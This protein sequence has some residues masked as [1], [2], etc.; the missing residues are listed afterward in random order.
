M[1]EYRQ[2]LE[3][4]YGLEKLG[5]VFG[6]DNITRLLGLIG[7]PQ[8]S[9]KAVH[10]AGTNGKG[11]VASMLSEVL[12]AAG[13]A[14]G[15]YTSPHLVS[16]TERIDANGD[17]IT[18]AEVAELTQYIKERVDR[19]DCGTPFTFFDFTTAIAFEYFKRK[20]VAIALVEVGLGGRLDSTNVLRPLVSVITNVAFDHQEYLGNSLKEIAREK[21]GIVK[22][23]VPVVT[24]AKG[25]PLE[26]VRAAAAKT[27]L[28]ALD[29]N[30]TYKKKGEQLMWYRGIRT[31]Y[32][33]LS[34]G[35]RGD[36]Q[37]FNAALALCTLELLDR[38]GFP[39]KEYAV[40]KGLA[41]IKW[42]ARLELV[43]K[44]GKPLI[45]IDGAH[46]PDGA[47]ALAAYLKGHFVNRKKLLI[48]GV[49]KDK[50]FREM[51]REL[52][53]VVQQTILTR[54]EIGR[55]ALPA[56]VARY[57]PGALVSPSVGDALERA[58]AMAEEHD[59]IIITGSFYTAGEAKGLLDERP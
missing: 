8:E 1:K 9:L 40:R 28:Y 30:F 27:A 16:F 23:N 2:T 17:R 22:E 38:A 54:P 34:V 55:A 24:G 59:L 20:D 26:V 45:L 4:L 36:H 48:F 5:M 33:D 7:N 3:Y 21:A 41:S 58:F 13:Y 6:L 15:M 42:P 46:N 29:E 19:Q 32:D 12:K 52:L 10:I 53:P 50:D 25:E 43:R 51:L 14:T 56:D 31:T 37:L 57:A 44:P 35:L 11:S 49:M 47:A 39:V 18:E